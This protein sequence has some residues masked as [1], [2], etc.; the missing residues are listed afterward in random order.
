MRL[1]MFTSFNGDR[2]G[3]PNYCIAITDGHSNINSEQTIPAADE[4]RQ[5]DITMVAV[6]IGENG[7]VD[8]AELNGIANDP[9]NAYAFLM[10]TEDQLETTANAILDMLC[11]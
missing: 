4:A 1:N 11:Q 8:R 3:D 6:G 5:A 9:D 2:A 7:H 10:E